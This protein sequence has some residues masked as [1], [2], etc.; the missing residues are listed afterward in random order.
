VNNIDSLNAPHLQ[1][2]SIPWGTQAIAAGLTTLILPGTYYVAVLAIVLLAAFALTAISTLTKNPR[3]ANPWS[4]MATALAFAYGLGSANSVITTLFSSSSDLPQLFQDPELICRAVG[5]I[6]IVHGLLLLIGQADRSSRIFFGMADLTGHYMISYLGVGISLIAWLFIALGKIGYQGNISQAGGTS[7]SIDPA[8]SLVLVSL[9]P[10]TAMCAAAAPT[11]VGRSRLPLLFVVASTVALQATQGRR[12]MLYSLFVILVG[13]ILGGLRI[14]F[15]TPKSIIIGIAAAT[16]LGFGSTF[17]Y[18]MR[19]AS[20]DLPS[21][22]SVQEL[23]AGAIEKMAVSGEIGIFED[24]GENLRTRSFI[25]NYLS[26]L[27]DRT[28]LLGGVNGILLV[29]GVAQAVPSVMFP[30]KQALL[31]MG[32]EEDIVHPH[33]GLPVF[34]EANSI[35]TTGVSDFG[36]PGLYIYPILL[37]LLYRTLIVAARR[38]PP[39]AT[40]GFGLSLFSQLVATEITLGGTMASI[41]DSILFGA[42]LAMVCVLLR[43]RG[44]NFH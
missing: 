40:F 35:L 8:A 2:S 39:L 5:H 13:A 17:F 6:S 15:R 41:R 18:A 3:G 14:S 43:G 16:A 10:I 38:A 36:L 30:N 23:A 4:V 27:I 32:G 20:V 22:A 1:E 26:L 11:T 28:D 31:D 34:D 12:Q 42:V 33:L 24:M 25:L 9:V 19:F 21:G 29:S 7:Y 44:E 37:C